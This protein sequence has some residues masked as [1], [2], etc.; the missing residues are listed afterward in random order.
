MWV[1]TSDSKSLAGCELVK[2][3][4]KFVNSIIVWLFEDLPLFGLCFC[5]QNLLGASYESLVEFVVTVI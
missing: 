5:I 2:H 3:I 1:V 4:L